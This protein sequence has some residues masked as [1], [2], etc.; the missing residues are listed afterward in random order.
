MTK[1]ES[2]RIGLGKKTISGHFS[3]TAGIL[4]S[5]LWLPVSIL[6]DFVRQRNM[7]NSFW[8]KQGGG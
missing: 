8:E 3:F 6:Q 4:S 1:S 2:Q 7:H 5:F